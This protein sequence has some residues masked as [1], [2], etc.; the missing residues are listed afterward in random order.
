M[1]T[2]L[3]TDAERV[4]TNAAW[5]TRYDEAVAGVLPSYFDLTAASAE[6]SWITDVEGRRYLDL[7][8]GIA[9]T[10]VGHRHPRVTAALHAQVDEL[11]HTSVVFRHRRYIELAEAIGRLMPWMTEPRTFL[12]NSGA[13]AVD[14]SV[15]L[16]RRVTGRPGVIA[17]RRAFHGRTLGATSLTTAKAK[18]REGYDPLL[19]SV[20]IAP[21]CIPSEGWTAE[22][23]LAAF[24]ELLDLQADPSTIAAVIVEPVLGEGGYVVPP[25]AWLAGLRERCDRHGML[26]VFDEVQT[27]FGRTGRPFAAEVFGVFPDVVL[28]AKGVASGLPLA[29]IVAP[30]AI[31]DRWPNA[32]HGSTF[33]G[34][35]VSCAA[36]LATI[37]VLAEEGCYDRARELGEVTIARLQ[38]AAVG[39]PAVRDVRGVGL[40][41]GVELADGATA[42]AVQRRCLDAGVV[43]LTCGPHGEVLRLIPPL[44]ISRDDLDHGIG[45]LVEAL[46]LA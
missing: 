14:G 33:G 18:Y 22:S 12:C 1:T 17:F 4:D 11:L 46:A 27:G 9:V 24:D 39:N 2:A 3:T 35:P 8:S 40:M 31:M 34:N 37:E 42:D 7:G 41:I 38:A 6:G 26:L 29:G 44:T 45:V 13:E 43:V 32:A 15:K 16:A 5:S 10:N 23:A 20:H 25:P 21:W 30:A 19:P 28:F 36:A